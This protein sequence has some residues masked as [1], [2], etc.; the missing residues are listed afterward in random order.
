MQHGLFGH[1]QGHGLRAS[2][3]ASGASTAST[4]DERWRRALDDTR[5]ALVSPC[6]WFWRV[7]EKALGF[8]LKGL[9]GRHFLYR[10]EFDLKLLLLP[11]SELSGCREALRA[12]M[13][14]QLIQIAG[15]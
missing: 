4:R 5:S 2:Q 15:G 12:R 8:A 13:L 14:V 6:Q 10:R 9:G 7:L 3:A 11:A 1:V